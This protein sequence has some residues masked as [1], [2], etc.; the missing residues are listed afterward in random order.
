MGIVVLVLFATAFAGGEA[1]V[2]LLSFI[3]SMD[4]A[5]RVFVRVNYPLFVAINT[6]VRF[7][8]YNM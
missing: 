6:G 2:R 8:Y 4:H 5:A 3:A 1:R 7:L